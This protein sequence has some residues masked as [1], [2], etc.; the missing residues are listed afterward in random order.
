MKNVLSEKIKVGIFSHENFAETVYLRWVPSVGDY[1]Q[2]PRQK[3]LAWKIEE[4]VLLTSGYEEWD[5]IVVIDK[6]PL[7][8]PSKELYQKAAN[9]IV[10]ERI[11]HIKG[12]RQDRTNFRQP[13]QAWQRRKA[14]YER[15]EAG[16]S[17]EAIAETEKTS[18]KRV[19][20][21]GGEWRSLLSR[22]RW[23]H[24]VVVDDESFDIAELD[25]GNA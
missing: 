10:T 9:E 2:L 13:G 19:K 23:H 6:S 14:I 16:E 3:K 22:L 1:I 18:V 12:I 7:Q 4:V 25:S 15:A 11:N 5:I 17:W 20:V 8:Y 24:E 21:L